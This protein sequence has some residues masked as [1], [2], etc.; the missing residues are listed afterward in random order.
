MASR[1]ISPAW[2]R[3]VD[4]L[5]IQAIKE[6]NAGLGVAI[7][8]ENGGHDPIDQATALPS[9]LA[10][11]ATWNPQLAYAAG[12]MIGEEARRKGLN[13]LLAGAANLARDPR[14]G[15]NFE[16]AG[17]DPLLTG[18][19]VGETIRGISDRHVISTIKHFALNDQE[20]KRNS[21]DALI[22]DAAFRE[23]DLLAFEI[24][25]ERGRPGAV[26][27]SYNL[28]NGVHA[29]EHQWLLDRVLRQEWGF[30]GWV[31]S[32]WGAAHST[33]TAAAAGLD[34]Q[35]GV[36]WDGQA[37]FGEPLATAVQEGVLPGG[38]LDAMALHV[39][40]ALFAAGVVDDPPQ[41]APLDVDADA[42]IA[43]QVAEQGIVLLK[44]DHDLLPLSR[45]A[46][47]IAVIGGHA[48]I[49]VMSGG[50]SS[51]VIPI[52]GPA[53]RIDY[54][55]VG[56]QLIF[57]PSVADAGDRSQAADGAGGLR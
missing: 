13:L 10:L 21:V 45:A 38:Q 46:R 17:E 53:L 28:V 49:G 37:Y 7:P 26:M 51:Q 55:E 27:C 3:G 57:D 54:P 19:I 15:R 35:S 40:H 29:C 5:G 2:C 1:C 20:T 22:D 16:Y 8:L 39:L 30:R 9:G 25:S 11:A 24:A 52:G 41:P 47:H 36:E 56:A 44:N 23:S 32:D 4:R 48:D 31:M 6:S 42:G 33:V 34:Q 14:S 43:R 18:T 50:G 12:S